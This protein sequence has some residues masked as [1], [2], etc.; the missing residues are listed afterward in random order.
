[1]RRQ[2]PAQAGF[3]LLEMLVGLTLLALI[4]VAV[5][6]SVR[7]GLRL[8]QAADANDSETEWQQ[9]EWLVERWLSRALTPRGYD[10][11]S[12][13]IFEGRP[14]GVTFL[15]D[16]QV[17]RKPS[18]YSRIGLLARSNPVCPGRAD[19][20]LTWEDVTMASN[21]ALG[22]SDERV[23]FECA[24]GLAFDYGGGPS[25]AQVP[26][27]DQSFRAND[28]LPRVVQVRFTSAGK[29]R[30]ISARLIYAR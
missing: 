9:T 5:T 26:S 10:L 23:L 29:A 17:G 4:S 1:M 3:S 24:D 19:L 20:V 11:D 30:T 15:V 18:G 27:P 22:A 8:W 12:R 2:R 6:Q 28:D 7:T 13:V 16:G 21:F 25:L 14:D